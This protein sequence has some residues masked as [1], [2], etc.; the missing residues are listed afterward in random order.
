MRNRSSLLVLVL[1]SLLEL[2]LLSLIFLPSYWDSR[3][4]AEA[5]IAKV[6]GHPLSSELEKEVRE[7]RR[8]KKRFEL[9]LLIATF[10]NG[11]VLVLLVVRR[12]ACARKT[13]QGPDK[14]RSAESRGAGRHDGGI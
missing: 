1:A 2:F 12:R 3:A 9:G 5:A 4:I 7:A 6:D 13:H 10:A 8:I 11:A 14:S